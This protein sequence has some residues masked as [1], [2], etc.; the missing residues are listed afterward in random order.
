M[1]TA[2]DVR[3]YETAL[4]KFTKRQQQCISILLARVRDTGGEAALLGQVMATGIA[5]KFIPIDKVEA[6]LKITGASSNYV[7]RPEDQCP[8][9]IIT[10]Q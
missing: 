5:V 6:I 9:S 10:D 4:I 8:I 3:G 2:K 7:Y 1:K